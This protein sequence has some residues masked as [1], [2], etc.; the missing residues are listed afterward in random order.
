MD[1]NDLSLLNVVNIA[2]S[3]VTIDFPPLDHDRMCSNSNVF[4]PKVGGPLLR[5]LS[6]ERLHGT[7][8]GNGFLPD[9]LPPDVSIQ[10]WQTGFKPTF[11]KRFTYLRT[12]SST[13]TTSLSRISSRHN[14]VFPKE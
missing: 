11:R 7:E 14:A 10:V 3:H 6:T 9:H 1:V 13:M 12:A 2:V 8:P 4:I 5:H